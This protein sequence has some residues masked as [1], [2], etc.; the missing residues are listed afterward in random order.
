M[1]KKK[2]DSWAVNEKRWRAESDARTIAQAEVIKS[3][4]ARMKAA[5]KA[6]Q[7]MYKD[8]L[9]EATALSKIAKQTK[10]RKK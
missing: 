10:P 7:N 3:D 9:T 5:A 4:P 6:A 8:E 1:A 2:A